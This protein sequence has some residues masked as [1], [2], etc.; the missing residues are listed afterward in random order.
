[1]STSVELGL[2]L[3]REF[4]SGQPDEVKCLLQQQGS[5]NVLL[6]LLSV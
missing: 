1:L 6:Q 5:N 4:S 2:G 3:G